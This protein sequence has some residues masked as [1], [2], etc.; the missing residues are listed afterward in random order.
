[1]EAKEKLN[2]MI[3][4][5]REIALKELRLL[6]DIKFAKNKNIQSFTIAMGTYF[7][8]NDKGIMHDFKYKAL[9]DFIGEW[10]SI[11]KL[12]GEGIIVKRD[13]TVITDW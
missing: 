4:Q 7:F 12:T 9:D 2:R 5:M 11:L 13:G 3:G 6:V 8:K 1:M 10:D